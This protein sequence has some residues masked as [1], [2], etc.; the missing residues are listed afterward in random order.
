VVGGGGGVGLP[1]IFFFA[2]TFC[3]AAFWRSPVYR[4]KDP[5]RACASIGETFDNCRKFSFQ[6]RPPVL[7]PHSQK[8]GKNT[9]ILSINNFA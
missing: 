9:L 3:L 5:L 7:R 4:A 2:R 6:F 1:E 8:A